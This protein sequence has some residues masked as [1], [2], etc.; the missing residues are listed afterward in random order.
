MKEITFQELSQDFLNQL[1]KSAF[2]TVKNDEKVNTMTIGWG[3]VGYIWNKPIL[4]VPVRYQRHTYSMIDQAQT[5]SVSVPVHKD[6]KK[7]LAFCGTKSGRDMDKIS[8]IGL[9]LEDAQMIDTPII[10][11]C[12]LHIECKTIY[13]QAMEPGNL[14]GDIRKASYPNNDFHVL[15]YGE[16]VKAY[17]K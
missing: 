6:M 10:A 13:K 9:A 14:V 15:Y 5:F 17:Y 4:I 11:D 2:L 16:I 3:T 12:D 8:E 7:A 1:V